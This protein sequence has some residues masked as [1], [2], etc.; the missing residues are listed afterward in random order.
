MSDTAIIVLIV[1]VAV[2]VV[3]FIF[4]RQLRSFVFKADKGG[5]QTEL[6]THPPEGARAPEDVRPPE[7]VPAPAPTAPAAAP[8]QPTVSIRGNVQQGADNVID[9]RRDGVEV[10]ENL[11]EGEGQE[12]S[13]GPDEG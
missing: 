12:I 9:V 11:Q 13:V 7:T 4:R 2:V 8:Q 5:L 3:L 6:T 1:A 10:V